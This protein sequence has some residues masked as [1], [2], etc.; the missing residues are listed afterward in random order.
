MPAV[1]NIGPPL[2]LNQTGLAEVAA[3]NS[4]CAPDFANI[5][6]KSTSR[7]IDIEECRHPV[8]EQILVEANVDVHWAD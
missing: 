4:Y 3:V 2:Q 1:D 7:E 6:A 5:E 8:V